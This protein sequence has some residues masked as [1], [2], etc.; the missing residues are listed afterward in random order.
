MMKKNTFLYLLMSIVVFLTACSGS[1]S[2]KEKP[3]VPETT[4]NIGLDDEMLLVYQFKINEGDGLKPAGKTKLYLSGDAIRSET[5]MQLFG[6]TTKMVMLANT[7]DPN[8]TILLDTE[9]KTYSKMDINEF[10]DDKM[11]K[12]M[13]DMQKDSLV[14]VGEEKLNGYNCT[15][16]N[17][18]T[19]LNISTA[20]AGIVGGEGKSVTQYWVTK[21]IPGYEKFKK[22]LESQPKI[23]NGSTAEI[24]QYGIPIKQVILES[25]EVNMVMEL[26]SIEQQSIPDSKFEIPSDYQES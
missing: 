20:M 1:T 25:G 5:E 4:L 8:K 18:V 11:V 24:Y 3:E 12:Q 10:A 6:Q 26:E 16:I 23:F 19:T 22:L 17:I 13:Q 14:V 21:D 7:D 15:K 9:K 2:S